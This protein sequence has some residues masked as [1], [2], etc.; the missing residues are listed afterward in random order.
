MNGASLGTITITITTNWIIAI[1]ISFK[2]LHV[3]QGR[4]L[5]R[6]GCFTFFLLLI[7]IITIV[8]TIFDIITS[9]RIKYSQQGGPRALPLV[10]PNVDPESRQE[11]VSALDQVGAWSR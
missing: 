9:T 8:I 11:A 1:N 3:S 5:E 2:M 4:P 10:V 7:T 6:F